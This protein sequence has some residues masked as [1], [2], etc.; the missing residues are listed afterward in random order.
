MPKPIRLVILGANGFLG[1]S[2][3]EY[4]NKKYSIISF[5]RNQ[6]DLTDLKK[7]EYTL[8][9]IR[10]DFVINAAIKGGRLLKNYTSD[11]FY[12]NLLMTENLLYVQDQIGF[13]LIHFGSA[14]K[15]DRTN[16]IKNL[17]EGDFGPVPSN[18]YSLSKY[19]T[20][21]RLLGNKDAIVLNIFNVFGEY[22][23]DDRFIK[24][25]ILK[26]IRKEPVSIW[27]DKLFDFFGVNDTVK[28][29]EYLLDNRPKN[30]YE[31]NLVYREKYLLSDIASMINQLDKHKIE[32]K[33]TDGPNK[34]Y[35]GSGYKL[36]D[37]KLNLLGLNQELKILYWKLKNESN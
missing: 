36:A 26:Y 37:L 13:K 1:R 18:F 3:S 4:L 7:L 27:G 32:V 20:A 2:L 16:D 24:S 15:E 34:E 17:K 10:P 21:K 33:I 14:A 35:W 31:L 28:V 12:Q 23:A 9:Y 19:F 6:L 30:Y 5:N 11:E 29:I 22:E 25:S 8:N